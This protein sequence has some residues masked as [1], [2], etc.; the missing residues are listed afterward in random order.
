M[1]H[2]TYMANGTLLGAIRIDAGLFIVIVELVPQQ[3]YCVAS[4][5]NRQTH[6]FNETYYDTY[7][8]ATK[9]FAKHV[10]KQQ[11]ITSWGA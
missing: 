5:L 4:Y 1:K 2:L 7:K 3:Q 6:R 10:L 11:H 8:D 9:G